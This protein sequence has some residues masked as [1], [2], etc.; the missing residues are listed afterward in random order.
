MLSIIIAFSKIRKKSS[1]KVAVPKHTTD[2]PIRLHKLC[3]VGCVSWLLFEFLQ[4]KMLFINSPTTTTT[5]SLAEY[6]LGV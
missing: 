1:G 4:Q 6:L 5:T 2:T 3:C